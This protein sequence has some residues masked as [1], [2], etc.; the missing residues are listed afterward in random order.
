[1]ACES[2][3]DALATAV[4]VQV[5]AQTAANI[6]QAVLAAANQA[7]YTAYYAYQMCLQGHGPQSLPKKLSLPKKHSELTPE[8]RAEFDG[9]VERMK[10]KKK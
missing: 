4:D 2:E 1:M 5:L 6:A 3:L 10:A 7:V 8:Q 9:F